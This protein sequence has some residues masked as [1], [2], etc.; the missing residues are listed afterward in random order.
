MSRVVSGIEKKNS[1][2]PFL[3][4][5]SEKPTKGLTALT[6]EIIKKSQ[7]KRFIVL[8]SYD[9]HHQPTTVHC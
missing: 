4:R 5:I 3:P 1:T 2:S 6:P 9:H 7:F 8:L